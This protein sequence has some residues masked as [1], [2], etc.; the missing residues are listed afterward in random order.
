MINTRGVN[1]VYDSI[2]FFDFSV[3]P[4]I[5]RGGIGTISTDQTVH[6]QKMQLLFLPTLCNPIKLSLGV[7][8][9]SVD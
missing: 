1:V 6:D 9:P 5:L 7:G 4:P 2:H 3:G 8:S